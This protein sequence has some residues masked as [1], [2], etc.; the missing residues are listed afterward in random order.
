MTH[1]QRSCVLRAPRLP[2]LALGL[3]LFG[4]SGPL[5]AQP[6]PDPAPTT[7]AA[8]RAKDLFVRGMSLFNEGRIE[9]ATD[10]L[11][12]SHALRPTR[13]STM[14]AA[15]C[16]AKLGRDDEALELYEEVFFEFKDQLSEDNRAQITATID[17]I[18]GRVG[19]VKITANASDLL[20]TEGKRQRRLRRG[21]R[22]HLLPGEHALQISASGYSPALERVTV[23][24]KTVATV[25]VE[26]V[27]TSPRLRIEE[28]GDGPGGAEV[29][30]DGARVGV[31]PW[32]GPV[33][34]GEHVIWFARGDVGTAPVRV[35]TPDHAT[36]RAYPLAGPLGPP[37]QIEVEP[38]TASISLDDVAVGRGQWKG[39]LP[40]GHH[41]VV[42][43]ELGYHTERASL[44]VTP[45]AAPPIVR[46]R[47]AMDVTHP[48]WPPSKTWHLWFGAF[49]GGALGRS[50]GSTAEASCD[51]SCS[52][53]S[54]VSGGIGGLRAGVRSPFD[55]SIELEGGWIS[56]HTS[57][58]RRLRSSGVD[59][60]PLTTFTLND[61]LD[62]GGPFLALGLSQRIALGSRLGLT[63]RLTA[64]VVFAGSSDPISGTATGRAGDTI[65][66]GLVKASKPVRSADAFVLPEVGVSVRLGDFDVSAGIA[67]G[68]FLADGPSLDHGVL[69]VTP[70]ACKGPDTAA[71]ACAPQSSLVDKDVGYG[72]FL[73]AIPRLELGY[74]LR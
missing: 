10:L 18:K 51:T 71:V 32:E 28:E 13:G 61:A 52:Q 50:L 54:L 20:V 37:L 36:T 29:F 59:G 56:L 3:V 49:G 34:V 6:T 11:L 58:V 19:G 22:L 33:A 16:L 5:H 40:L 39:R 23:Q 30:V 47:L 57:L 25:A 73:V 45:T 44:A 31:T 70:G 2:S 72:P 74:T 24:A 7:E 9:E 46:L 4:L 26:L 65:A 63:A 21:E 38:V 14:N 64:G 8:A 53:R 1:R 62:F 41:V 27:P 48:R 43:S 69:I 66:A 42:G 15:N 35:V 12:Q 55:L 67:L 60:N 68:A 17:E